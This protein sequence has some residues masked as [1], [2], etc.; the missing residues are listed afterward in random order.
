MEPLLQSVVLECFCR[1]AMQARKERKLSQEKLSQ[2]LKLGQCWV[3]KIESGGRH[4]HVIELPEYCL[5]LG[6]GMVDFI[7]RFEQEL[8]LAAMRSRPSDGILRA[9]TL[10]PPL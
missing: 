10:P 7:A 8:R 4:L 6:L 1:V 2:A 5:A 9:R 3:S